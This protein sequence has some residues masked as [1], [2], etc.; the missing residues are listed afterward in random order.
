MQG[1]LEIPGKSSPES[2]NLGT[3]INPAKPLR[4][5]KEA[6]PRKS[7]CGLAREIRLHECGSQGQQEGCGL[8]EVE[9]FI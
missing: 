1:E 2:Q 4:R 8:R 7:K 5:R 9:N 6:S 3:S